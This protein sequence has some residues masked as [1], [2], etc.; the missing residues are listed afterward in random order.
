M[1]SLVKIPL[2]IV[3]VFIVVTVL[4]AVFKICPPPGPWPMPPWCSKANVV[5]PETQ[6]QPSAEKSSAIEKKISEVI[7]DVN[8]TLTVP[9][10]T[11]GD[12]YLGVGDNSTFLRLTKINEVIYS[13][14][15]EIAKGTEYYYV[16][17]DGKDSGDKRKVETERIDDYVVDWTGINKNIF[18]ADF[19]KDVFIGACHHC[20][21]S[22]TKGN[23]VE[24]FSRAMDDVKNMG[25]NW[26]NLVPVWFVVPDYMGNEVKPIYSEDFKGDTGWITATIKDEDL[27]TLIK[28]AH[29][30]GLKVYLVPHVSVENWGPGIKAKGDLDAQNPDLFFESYEKFQ[31]HYAK[32]AQDNNVEMYSVGNEM[33]SSAHINGILAK[34]GVDVTAKWK[35]VIKTVKD[36]Y[37]GQVGYSVSCTI[38]PICGPDFVG[39]WDA[40]DFIGWE[41][42]VP[43]ATGEHESIS[44][45]KINANRIVEKQ[46]KPLSE[47]YNKPVIITEIGWEAYPGACAHT[48][49]TGPSKGGD[50]IEQASCY[51]AVLQAIEGKPY[52][53]GIVVWMYAAGLPGDKF[54]YVYTDSVNEIRNSITEKEIAKWFKK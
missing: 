29:S 16:S 6:E 2:I 33:D 49:G 17:E 20:S 24:P 27:V 42:Y 8:F 47:K 9:Y 14:K 35:D 10:W 12:V 5:V 23:F 28:T 4:M 52:I 1:K 3:G 50:R 21:V 32:I 18:P 34:K 44:S 22:I 36:I 40:L 41:W 30:K 26:I 13:G 19:Q 43:I 15:A 46:I 25:G 45:M 48:Y 31:A 11:K 7:L 51:E 37:K 54:E 53:K 39:F 38:E